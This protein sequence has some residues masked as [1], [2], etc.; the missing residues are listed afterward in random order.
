MANNSFANR[1]NVRLPVNEDPRVQE[2]VALHVKELAEKDYEVE[3]LGTA[4]P[5]VLDFYA[6]GSKAGEDLAPR[7]AAVAEKFAGKVRFLKVLVSANAQ[8]AATFGVTATPT[9]VFLSAGK[10]KGERLS[11]EDIKRADVK[12]RVEAMLGIVPVTQKAAGAP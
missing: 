9:L 2:L 6:A 5:V 8:L 7:L 3:V 10:E 12:A 4:L 1:F 11:G